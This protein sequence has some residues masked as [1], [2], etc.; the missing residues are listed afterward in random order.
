M[1]S[2]TGQKE[3]EMKLVSE[4]SVAALWALKPVQAFSTAAISEQYKSEP[5]HYQLFKI[6]SDVD[7]LKQFTIMVKDSTFLFFRKFEECR[8]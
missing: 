8:L 1:H 3:R 5:P 4:E 6:P 2:W 7:F